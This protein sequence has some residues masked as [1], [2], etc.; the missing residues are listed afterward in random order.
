M[1]S[2]TGTERA[3]SP[4]PLGPNPSSD[5]GHDQPACGPEHRRAVPGPAQC[6]DLLGYY[7]LDPGI[8]A[9]GELT[10]RVASLLARALV[11]TGMPVDV[12]LVQ[13]AALLHDVGK[14]VDPDH[15]HLASRRIVEAHGWP[16]L[17]PPVERHLT[18]LI[19]T[20][21]GPVSWEEK[22][23]YYAD[24]LCT[25]R[26]VSLAERV[27]DLCRRYPEHAGTFQQCLPAMQALESEIFQRLPWARDQLL[28]QL[29][30]ALREPAARFS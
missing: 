29:A 18:G 19:L 16:A 2:Q 20:G 17:G 12:E 15:H 23:V 13:A 21:K 3:G 11:T 22:L 7:S 8:I 9:H 14:A 27:D 24:K 4:G 28:I 1:H 5:P 30:S 26:V 10:A 25:T 6:A